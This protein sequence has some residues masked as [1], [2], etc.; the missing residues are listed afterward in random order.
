MKSGNFHI[1]ILFL[2]LA[3]CKGSQPAVV[4]DNIGIEENINTPSPPDWVLN[5]PQSS[6]YYFG[7]GNAPVS[8]PN[9]IQ[10]AQNKA[11]DD[12]AAEISI[13]ISS[14][15]ILHLQESQQGFSEKYQSFISTRTEN[16]LENHEG[17]GTWNDGSYY[18]TCYRLSK[19]EYQDAQMAKKKQAL[20]KALDHYSKA[21]EFSEQQQIQSALQNYLEVLVSLEQHL[22]EDNKAEFRGQEI[23][24]ARESWHNLQ[25]LLNAVTL[26]GPNQL[27]I[28]PIS[29]SGKVFEYR[30]VVQKGN[31]LVS[32]GQLPIICRSNA[33]ILKKL[34]DDSGEFGLYTN[35]MASFQNQLII[36]IDLEHFTAR[37]PYI[38]QQL[39]KGLQVRHTAIQLEFLPLTAYINTIEKNLGETKPGNELRDILMKSLQK[40]RIYFT[41]VPALA[42]LM[43]EVN[44]DTRKGKETSGLF[45]SFLEFSIHVKNPEGKEIYSD[46]LSNIKGIRLSYSEAGL[47]AYQS[48]ENVVDEELIGPMMKTINK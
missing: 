40:H 20:N 5:K 2:L 44:A 46:R 36:S 19:K 9:Y 24:L 1:A 7:V 31:G 39:S 21:F 48:A 10:M 22:N 32:S 6:F 43:I 23:D 12:L 30:I 45:T 41:E 28:K 35:E 14:H 8:I 27:Q 38:I 4:Q 11:L 47:S 17:F 37:L 16:K 26:Q 3:G 25:K 29:S 13:H 34:S 42:D 33:T 15:S 18:W